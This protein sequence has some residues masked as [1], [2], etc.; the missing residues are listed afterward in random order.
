MQI[1]ATNIN[2]LGAIQVV[3]SFLDAFEDFEEYRESEVY[4]SDKGELS[5]YESSFLNIKVYRRILP[6]ALSRVFE[7]VFSFFLFKNIPTIVLGDI[8]LRG[9]KE[10]VVLVHYPYMAYPRVNKF[11]SKSL[12]ARV[13]RFL[14][15]AN[16]KYT[17]TIIVQT[18]A[19][20]NDL[21]ESYPEIKNKL[22]ICPQPAPN[23]LKTHQ[24]AN[25]I[26]VSNKKYLFYP[27]TYSPYKNHDFLLKLN[28]YAIEN[29]INISN[30]EIQLTLREEEFEKYKFINF[31]KNLG[32]LNTDEMN[33]R[34]EKADALLFMSSIETYGLPIV[35][36]LTINL[37]I[38]I[39]DFNYSRWICDDKAYYFQHSSEESFFNN[40]NRLL[41]DLND[42]KAMDYSNV[43]KKFPV[44]WDTVV[45]VFIKQLTK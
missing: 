39:A 27:A 5:K 8:P 9:I 2:G 17:K 32:R 37:P 11:S 41:N 12:S 40:L 21:I 38:L 29:N 18:G 7:S 4:V 15:S 20:A 34:Y 3:K 44:S 42:G 6:K 1:H 14:F 16:L 23:W 13:V 36:S 35:E 10:Q 31:V 22:V 33:F 30:I 43:L 26:K 25:K 45:D 24:K 28:D 19:M